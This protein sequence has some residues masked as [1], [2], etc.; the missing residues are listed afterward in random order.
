VKFLSDM[1]VEV[2]EGFVGSVVVEPVGVVEGLEFDVLD[3][4]PGTFGSDEFG[5]V[6]PELG[7]GQSVVVGVADRSDRRVDAGFD[8]ACLLGGAARGD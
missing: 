6:E 5:L 1:W 8:E 7:L 4:A 3:A 2:V